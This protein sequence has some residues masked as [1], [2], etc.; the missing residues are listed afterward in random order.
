MRVDVV[1]SVEPMS[2]RHGRQRGLRG[3]N[4]IELPHVVK[5]EGLMPNG[6]EGFFEP[7]LRVE[8]TRLYACICS[9]IDLVSRMLWGWRK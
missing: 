5:R 2:P 8:C 4:S 9:L 7:S 1:A 3:V 6:L